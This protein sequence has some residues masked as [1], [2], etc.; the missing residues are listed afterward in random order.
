MSFTVKQLKARG[1]DIDDWKFHVLPVSGWGMPEQ[2]ESS[3]KTEPKSKYSPIEVKGWLEQNQKAIEWPATLTDIRNK[4][5]RDIIGIKNSRDNQECM[6][7][8]T[9]RRFILPQDKE[10]M[11]DGQ[12]R[13]KYIINPE[14]IEPLP[15]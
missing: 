14:F 15:F 5:F 4:I 2:I 12:R 1:R 7:I 3:A 10:D 6:T 8:A 9:N 13:P 11:D